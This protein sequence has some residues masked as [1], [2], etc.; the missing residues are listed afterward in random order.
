MKKTLLAIT[1]VVSSLCVNAH[2]T[3]TEF[4]TGTP[5][6]YSV[7]QG[8]YVTGNHAYGDLAKGMRYN[9]QNGMTGGG[10]LTGVLLTV[11][12]KVDDGSGSITVRV[13]A[14]SAADTLGAQLGSVTIPLSAI[15]TTA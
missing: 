5:T 7:T 3:L 8:G 2:D 4:F 11:P 12:A 6:Y 9:G 13:F 10:T 14:Y 1:A 15:D